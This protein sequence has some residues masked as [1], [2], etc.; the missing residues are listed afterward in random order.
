LRR[1]LRAWDRYN[2]DILVFVA[3]HPEH[4][5][6]IHIDDLLR[7]SDQIID[8]ANQEWDFSLR[9]IPIEDV[10]VQRSLR[11]ERMRLQELLASLLVPSCRGTYRALEVW[12]ER[13]L[14]Q[15]DRRSANGRS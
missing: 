1:Y 13:T 14:R 15:L 8:Y 11:T 12:R 5:L 10:Y 3:A 9:S 6:V 4:T 2:R 7:L